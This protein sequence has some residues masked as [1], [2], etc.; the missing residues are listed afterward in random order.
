MAIIRYVDK[1]EFSAAFAFGEITKKIFTGE[2]V[3]AW[4][5]MLIYGLIVASVLSSCNSRT[6]IGGF[7]IAVSSTTV[8]AQV[9]AEKH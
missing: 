7:I 1:G 5:I 6:A 3:G 8:F 2:Y 9:Y 4:L